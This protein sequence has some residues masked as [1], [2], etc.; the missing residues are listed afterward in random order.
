M[1]ILFGFN[2]MDLVPGSR[3]APQGNEFDMTQEKPPSFVTPGQT[4]RIAAGATVILPCR[5]TQP[6]MF[7]ISIISTV[8]Y[9]QTI[10]INTK[11]RVD[12]P[13]KAII[14]SFF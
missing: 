1:Y 7:F 11:I 3:A 8:W 4:Y 2:V 10:V 6:G 12:Q 5:I 9:K 13:L 14:Y